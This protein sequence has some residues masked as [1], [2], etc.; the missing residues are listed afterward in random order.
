MDLS[1]EDFASEVGSSGPVTISGLGTRGG[2]VDGIREVR[3][4]VGI[5]RV[6][7]AEMVVECG[8]G[9]PVHE[10]LEELA[11]HG[12]GL[13]IPAGGSIGGALAAGRNDTTRLGYGPM[14]DI[15]LQTRYVSGLGKITKAGGP[16]VK[17][18]SGFDLCRLLVGSRGTLGFLGEVIMRTRPLPRFSGWFVAD[19]DPIVILAALYRPTTVLWNGSATWALLEGDETD[20]V[21]EADHVGLAATDGPPSLPT[22]FRW[23]IR[24]DEI[25]DRA[26]AAGGEFVAEMGVGTVHHSAPAP[27]DR[28]DPVVVELHRRIKAEFD[29]EGRLNPGVDVLARA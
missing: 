2:A 3:A 25:V 26:P 28:A 18:V 13:A 4:P 12:Q 17:N 19:A 1:L 10:V 14:R 27:E 21:A 5:S 15:L 20:V 23:S 22:A 9:T 16:T 29:P 11:E 6:D 8:A 7:A 24:P